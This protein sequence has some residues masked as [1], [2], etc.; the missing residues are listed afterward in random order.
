MPQFARKLCVNSIGVSV[1]VVEQ[2]QIVKI[3]IEIAPI[4]WIIFATQKIEDSI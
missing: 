4:L 2:A 1:G 3:V